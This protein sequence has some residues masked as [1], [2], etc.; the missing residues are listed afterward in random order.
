MVVQ[1]RS[2]YASSIQ[3]RLIMDASATK[4]FP[5]DWKDSS[6]KATGPPKVQKYSIDYSVSQLMGLPDVAND[7]NGSD[8]W[9]PVD[10]Q[11]PADLLL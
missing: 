11:Y 2:H 7:E 6:P 9:L 5:L 3:K 1:C 10:P 4:N 8:K